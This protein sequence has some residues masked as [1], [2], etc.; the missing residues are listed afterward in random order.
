MKGAEWAKEGSA[1]RRENPPGA[2]RDTHPTL[3]QRLH[4][5]IH[6]PVERGTRSCATVVHLGNSSHTVEESQQRR[7]LEYAAAAASA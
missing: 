2:T 4:T 5:P 7:R 6:P 3:S 1:P